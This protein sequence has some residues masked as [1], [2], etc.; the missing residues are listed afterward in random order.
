MLVL[1]TP[2]GRSAKR[3][4]LDALEQEEQIGLLYVA[5]F[6]KVDVVAGL[7]EK[8]SDEDKLP[9][10]AAGDRL[11]N[12]KFGVDVPADRRLDIKNGALLSE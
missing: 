8:E 11:I 5:V 1:G 12:G 7:Q 2:T 4:Y 3:G 9:S 6:R 10:W